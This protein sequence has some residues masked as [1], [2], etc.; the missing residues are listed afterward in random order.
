MS[1]HNKHPT[2]AQT[3]TDS[4]GN[5]ASEERSELDE[6]RTFLL[7][8]KFNVSLEADKYYANEIV[9]NLMH[10]G[11]TAEIVDDAVVVRRHL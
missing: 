4:D 8:V 2:D 1:K 6:G 7:F 9:K 10:L 5:V 11:Y 3:T